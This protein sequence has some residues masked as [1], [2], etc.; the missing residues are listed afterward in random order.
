[1]I[2][3]REFLDQMA[4]TLRSKGR[5]V[6]VTEQDAGFGKFVWLSARAPHWFDA[7]LSL[8]A[9]YSNRTGRWSLGSLQVRTGSGQKFTRYTRTAIR[10]AVDTWA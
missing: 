7:T 5:E 6:E 8:S 3:A 10:I 4:D 2:N 9:A 1:M